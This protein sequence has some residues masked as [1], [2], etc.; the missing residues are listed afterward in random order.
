VQQRQQCQHIEGN[1]ASAT[2]AT[3]PAQQGRQYQ[4]NKGKETYAMAMAPLQQWQQHQCNKVGDDTNAMMWQCQR[5]N[6]NYPSVTMVTTLVQQGQQRRRNNGKGACATTVMVPSQQ[7]QRG[8]HN[9]S[10]G[11]IATMAKRPAQQCSSS[12]NQKAW[13][14]VVIIAPSSSLPETPLPCLLSSSSHHSLPLCHLHCHLPHPLFLW[15]IVVCWA[16]GV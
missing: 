4:C 5:G 7:R 6:D 10:N 2:A 14:I 8:Q 1:N 9:N 3:M 15:L 16:Y 13:H 11:T 12:T